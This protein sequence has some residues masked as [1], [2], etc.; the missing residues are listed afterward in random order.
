MIEAGVFSD[1]LQKIELQQLLCPFLADL[2]ALQ[3]FQDIADA[4]GFPDALFTYHLFDR[5]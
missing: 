5:R 3:L 1:A 2:A 4:H